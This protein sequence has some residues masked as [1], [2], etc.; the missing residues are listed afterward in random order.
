[1]CINYL[2]DPKKSLSRAR[3]LLPLGLLVVSGGIAWPHIALSLHIQPGMNDGIQGFC[4]G[5]GIALEI[6]SA[7]L[8]G[9]L[10][11]RPRTN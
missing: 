8:V 5:L 1:M 11:N 4:L 10:R 6:G 3:L 9:K 7:V 2:D